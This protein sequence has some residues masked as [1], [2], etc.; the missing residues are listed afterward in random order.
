[1]AYKDL[2]ETLTLSFVRKR[3]VREHVGFLDDEVILIYLGWISVGY[4]DGQGNM[5]FD[6]GFF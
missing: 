4:C 3:Y 2:M 5:C 6:L 1:M